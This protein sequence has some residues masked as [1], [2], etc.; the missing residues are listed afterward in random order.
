MRSNSQC[1][2]QQ[3]VSPH[4]FKLLWAFGLPSYTISPKGARGLK[5]KLLSLRPVRLPLPQGVSSPD[6]KRSIATKGLDSTLNGVYRDLSAFLCF[7]PLVINKIELSK[8]TVQLPEE[9]LAKCDKLLATNPEDV[10][11]LSSRALQR[12]KRFEDAL[13]SYDRALAIQPNHVVVLR[14]RGN[15][16]LEQQRFE[17][18]LASYDKALTIGPERR[19][20]AQRPRL[21]VAAAEAVRGRTGEL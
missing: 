16:L 19:H 5:S 12:L 4:P 7:P 2:Q 21:R 8:S 20:H 10:A 18:A 17:E 11:T 9:E 1:F 15:A 3:S 14:N 6:H 13:E